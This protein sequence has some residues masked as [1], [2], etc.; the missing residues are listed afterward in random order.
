MPPCQLLSG[1]ACVPL[2]SVRRC[3]APLPEGFADRGSSGTGQYH[4]TGERPV[5]TD[6]AEPFVFVHKSDRQV[7]E[8]VYIEIHIVTVNIDVISKGRVSIKH[9]ETK[10]NETSTSVSSNF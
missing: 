4:P 8:V 6:W 1:P 5:T 2:Q 10:K 9:V 7:T 3:V